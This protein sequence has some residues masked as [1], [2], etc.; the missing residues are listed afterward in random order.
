ME[1]GNALNSRGQPLA[2]A[3]VWEGAAARDLSDLDP[4]RRAAD[5][6][7][8]AGDRA[9]AIAV[10]RRSIDARR[11]PAAVYTRDHLRLASLHLQQSE[12]VAALGQ[13]QAAFAANPA[14][15]RAH[16][17]E[18]RRQRAALDFAEFWSQFDSLM[19]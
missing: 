1:L 10:L 3:R 19:R 6:R 14:Y 18:L 7:E 16:S 4:A 11:L 13:L 12:P 9:G 2:A 17:R 5:A 8:A 15:A